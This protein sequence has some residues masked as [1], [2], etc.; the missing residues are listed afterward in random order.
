MVVQNYI[1][2]YSDEEHESEKRHDALYRSENSHVLL[3][4]STM[5]KKSL[6]LSEHRDFLLETGANEY[7]QPFL[8]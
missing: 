3:S 2:T 7:P 8:L 6:I 1:E 4:A 5:D